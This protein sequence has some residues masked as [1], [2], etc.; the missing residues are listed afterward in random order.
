[1]GAATGKV[2]KMSG[3]LSHGRGHECRSASR[4]ERLDGKM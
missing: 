3:R 4:A 2:R 1:M